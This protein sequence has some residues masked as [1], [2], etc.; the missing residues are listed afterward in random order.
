M[1]EN[2]CAKE[3]TAGVLILSQRLHTKVR[4]LFFPPF[5]ST[6]HVSFVDHRWSYSFS[7]SAVHW[8][9]GAA[10]ATSVFLRA[11]ARACLRASPSSVTASNL[12]KS[13][14]AFRYLRHLCLH[15][16]RPNLL[17][18]TLMSLLDT[19]QLCRPLLVTMP[20]NVSLRPDKQK[21]V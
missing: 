13:H 3:I 1:T 6:R 11:P 2:Y 10:M 12:S 8:Q 14:N 16:S 7:L 4:N 17:K 15:S 20:P 21:L 9:P 5:P 19:H 18:L